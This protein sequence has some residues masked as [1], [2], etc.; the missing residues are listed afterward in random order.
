MASREDRGRT[1]TLLG[2]GL[3]LIGLLVAPAACFGTGLCP[4]GADV[5]QP[6][7]DHELALGGAH[8]L[9]EG[10]AC[11]CGDDSLQEV[12][13]DAEGSCDLDGIE[14]EDLEG[15]EATLSCP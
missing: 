15:N 1:S 4:C 12:P 13:S 3:A 8:V 14:C 7:V 6:L 9:S 2:V 11:R 5:D 10:C